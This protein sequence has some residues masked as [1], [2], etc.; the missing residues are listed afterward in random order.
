[1]P[2]TTTPTQLADLLRRLATNE[3][4]GWEEGSGRRVTLRFRSSIQHT[5]ST[6]TH[7]DNE[8]PSVTDRRRGMNPAQ[9]YHSSSVQTP[10]QPRESGSGP[11]RSL[12]PE[13]QAQVGQN[14]RRDHVHED[15]TRSSWRS[16]RRRRSPD[17]EFDEDEWNHGTDGRNEED[18]TRR[19]DR[20]R[21]VEESRPLA[22]AG[23][24]R[25]DPSRR[26]CTTPPPPHEGPGYVRVVVREIASS[27]PTS[28][29][30]QHD[31]DITP[32]SPTSSTPR[33]T[34]QSEASSQDTTQQH[35]PQR[36][37]VHYARRH[38]QAQSHNINAP[39]KQPYN[40]IWFKIRKWTPLERLMT[41]YCQRASRNR[42]LAEFSMNGRRLC[43]DQTLEG[44]LWADGNDENG[45]K[46]EDVADGPVVI[47]VNMRGEK[48]GR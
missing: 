43:G 28:T 8:N 33:P 26:S 19:A 2:A 44:L 27:G 23:G 41:I 35:A 13:W 34:S 1:M 48:V 47:L 29:S 42:H 16:N 25:Q 36:S 7:N 5:A 17:D 20:P 15:R 37:S 9:F 45:E 46:R 18:R 6:S 22:L 24:G 40:G 21:D 32:A 4:E 12:F 38:S 14:N 39:T 31:S 11:R 10:Q 3:L 30:T